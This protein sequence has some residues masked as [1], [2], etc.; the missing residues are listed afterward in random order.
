MRIDDEQTGRGRTMGFRYMRYHVPE[1]SL[2]ER[3]FLI[4]WVACA[5]ILIITVE[6]KETP[7]QLSVFAFCASIMVGV[8][9]YW[10]RHEPAY[11]LQ[12]FLWPFAQ[13]MTRWPRIL[14][15]PVRAFGC[16]GFII[17]VFVLPLLFLPDWLTYS[18][19][20]A[21]FMLASELI[22]TVVAL[23]KRKPPKDYPQGI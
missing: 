6:Q 4:L 17:A 11:I 22:I 2:L 21:V 15:W 18:G 10:M 7:Q 20:G 9:G 19:S 5:V 13:Q 23:W 14:L 3:L 12:F 8:L 16:I 1:L